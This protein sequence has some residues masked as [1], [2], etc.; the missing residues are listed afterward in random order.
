MRE[1]DPD[2]SDPC[3]TPWRACSQAQV[4]ELAG[5]KQGA[6]KDAARAAAEAEGAQ[7]AAGRA[8]DE[9][10][11]M[12]RQLAELRRE[13]QE[14]EL[15]FSRVSILVAWVILLTSYH[16]QF[17]PDV[18]GYRVCQADLLAEQITSRTFQFTQVPVWV[19]DAPSRVHRPTCRM[20][21]RR[22]MLWRRRWR[23]CSGRRRPRR[24]PCSRWQPCRRR[25]SEPR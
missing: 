2:A 10:E 13:A 17:V 11:E 18:E 7:K 4:A 15:A 20:S 12:R 3:R 22:R 24:M 23:P 25:C 6:D 14:A 5:A 1:L 16:T 21:R 19:I 9:V 8:Q